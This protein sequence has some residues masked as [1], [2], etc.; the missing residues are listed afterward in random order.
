MFRQILAGLLVCALLLPFAVSGK[1]HATGTAPAVQPNAAAAATQATPKLSLRHVG[2][3]LKMT[4][5]KI[6]SALDYRKASKVNFDGGNSVHWNNTGKNTYQVRSESGQ[7]LYK[8]SSDSAPNHKAIKLKGTADVESFA[9]YQ[10]QLTEARARIDLTRANLEGLKL[11]QG[12]GTATKADIAQIK[13]LES[14]LPKYEKAYK[15]IEKQATISKSGLSG[16]LKAGFKGALTTA[17]II[18][19]VSIL[20]DTINNDGEINPGR[21]LSHM[22]TPRFLGGLVGCCCLGE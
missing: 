13:K 1:S 6:G 19:G 12:A 17:G 16:T 7:V 20:T 9:R 4:I 2:S 11:K 3:H 8:G 22:A 15:G 14:N 18:A 21:A 5:N 10:G